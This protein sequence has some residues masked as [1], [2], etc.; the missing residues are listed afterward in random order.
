MERI[1][2]S[3]SDWPG[4]W[5]AMTQMWCSEVTPQLNNWQVSLDHFFMRKATGIRDDLLCTSRGDLCSI[6]TKADSR[7]SG[8]KLQVFHPAS[9]SEIKELILNP[10]NKWH[11]LDR[12]P[13][14]L[15]RRCIDTLLQPITAIINKSLSE[16][17]MPSN[18]K[19]A[20]VTQ[21][22]KKARMDEKDM[23]S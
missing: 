23:S 1:K 6:A 2:N 12:L 7:I 8:E 18:L 4:I 3:S 19:W 22:P 17:L 15:L 13:T 21:L 5:W 10:P 9:D 20:A 16:G 11:D 14:W